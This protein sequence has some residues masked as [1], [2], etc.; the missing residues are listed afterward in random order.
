VSGKIMAP[1]TITTG[2]KMVVD[3]ID[4]VGDGADAKQS[5]ALKSEL[6]APGDFKET[7]SLEGDHVLVRA[8]DDRNGDGECSAGEAWGETQ[9]AVTQD[10]VEPVSLTLTTAAC[11][12]KLE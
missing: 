6:K 3:F 8:I 9:A 1:S 2:D 7:V 11:P 5:L 12:A 10:K 4:V